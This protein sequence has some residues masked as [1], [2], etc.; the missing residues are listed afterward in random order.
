MLSVGRAQGAW[1]ERAWPLES[2]LPVLFGMIA[3]DR[4]P[5]TWKALGPVEHDAGAGS[6][7][8]SRETRIQ[9]LWPPKPNELLMA[10]R[11]RTSRAT[12]GT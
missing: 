8:S 1:G 2:A 6:D 11:I 3:A 9:A 7:Q 4:L 12:L 5:T 10:V